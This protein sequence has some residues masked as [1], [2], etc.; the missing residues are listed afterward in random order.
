MQSETMN[1]DVCAADF[2]FGMPTEC[3]T[4]L[5]A[6]VM[7]ILLIGASL[8]SKSPIIKNI[9]A[10]RSAEGLSRTAVYGETIVYLNLAL[11][12]FL[13]GLPWSA[14]GEYIAL[15]IQSAVISFMTWKFWAKDEVSKAEKISAVGFGIVYI[16]FATQLLPPS[17]QYLLTSSSLPI[18]LYARGSQILATHGQKHT[19]ALSIISTSLSLGGAATRVLTTLKEVGWDIPLLLPFFLGILLN[20]IVALQYIMYYDNTQ[21]FLERLKAEKDQKKKS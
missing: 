11:Y 10:A 7:G 17:K 15:V 12:G 9:L 2:P 18:L 14:Y 21:K 4:Q 1:P 6:K 13:Q 5:L 8:L 20:S 19:G 16:I 3:S